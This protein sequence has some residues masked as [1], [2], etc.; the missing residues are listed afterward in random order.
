M[1][2]STAAAIAPQ[3]KQEYMPQQQIGL[4]GVSNTDGYMT[5]F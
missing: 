1:A 3:P 4:S 2:H 5:V